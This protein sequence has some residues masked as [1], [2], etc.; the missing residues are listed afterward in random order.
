MTDENLSPAPGR[1]PVWTAAQ[2]PWNL[3]SHPPHPSAHLTAVLRGGLLCPQSPHGLPFRSIHVASVNQVLGLPV[4]PQPTHTH[5]WWRDKPEFCLA[6]PGGLPV[7]LSQHRQSVVR[8]SMVASFKDRLQFAEVATASTPHNAAPVLGGRARAEQHTRG[9]RSSP[10][11]GCL[12]SGLELGRGQPRGSLEVLG[13]SPGW[14]GRGL[15][16]SQKVEASRH[17]CI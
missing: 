11:S 2:T 3:L 9:S 13:Q 16:L 7:W 14:A 6:Q 12:V 5:V 10:T 17:D 4:C 15:S 8:S 1:C